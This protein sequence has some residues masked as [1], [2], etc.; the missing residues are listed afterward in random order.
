M[1]DIFAGFY[2]I[3]SVYV[4]MIYNI[5]FDFASQ[6]ECYILKQKI[7]IIE[8]GCR[9]IFLR[10]YFIY[11]PFKG[12]S[13]IKQRMMVDDEIKKFNYFKWMN[14]ISISFD[15]LYVMAMEFWELIFWLIIFKIWFFLMDNFGNYNDDQSFFG[16]R[17]WGNIISFDLTY[18]LT[19]DI[20]IIK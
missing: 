20:S 17:T 11:K 1:G 5:S 9:R 16:V 8:K 13:G 15:K 6:I 2:F 10:K 19:G 7:K 12:F 4:H 18:Y 14:F 3:L